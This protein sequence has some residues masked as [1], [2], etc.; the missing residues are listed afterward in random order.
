MTEVES[1]MVKIEIRITDAEGD[2]EV[3]TLWATPMGKDLY[4]L[5]NSPWFAYGVSYLDIVQA[6]AEGDGFPVFNTVVEKSGNRTV[7]IILD[8]PAEEANASA[9]ILDALVTMGATYEGANPSYMAVN[10]EPHVDF[11]AICRFLTERSVQWE[12]ADPTYD[13]MYPTNPN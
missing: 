6:R 9:E 13:Q 7:R 1:D 11:A 4:R 10:I 12:H 5:E 3:E 8:P 2:T